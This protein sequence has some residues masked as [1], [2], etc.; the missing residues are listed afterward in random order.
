MNDYCNKCGMC[1]KLIPIDLEKKLIL[2]DG[3]QVLDDNFYS[4]LVKIS[5]EEAC[6]INESLVKNVHK[7]FPNAIFCYCEYLSETNLCTNPEKPEFCQKFPSYPLAFID[8][9][10][11]Y[12]GKIFIKSE[13]VKRKVRK[14][15]EEILYYESIIKI[16]L[17]TFFTFSCWQI[18]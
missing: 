12:C 9:D 13:E 5:L 15:K 18:I 16:K 6:H 1:C 11:G 2:R 14:Y 4:K 3:E 17:N 10:C 8:E 7:I